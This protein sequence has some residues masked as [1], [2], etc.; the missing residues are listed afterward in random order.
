MANVAR[1]QITITDLN[2]GKSLMFYLSSNQGT[3]QI[4]NVDT[5]TYTPNYPTSPYLVITPELYVSGTSTNVIA[6][7]KAR[8]TVTINGT[9][10]TTSNNTTYSAVVASASP[11]KLTIKKNLAANMRIEYTGI[12]VDPDTL[13]ETTVR[14]GITITRL[15]TAGSTV[16]PFVTSSGEKFVNGEVSSIVL[17]CDVHRGS[18][19]DTTNITYQWQRKGDGV[20]GQTWVNCTNTAN[21]VAGATTQEMTIYPDAVLN[22]D[23][24]RCVITDTDANSATNGQS[25][26]SNT[27]SVI[28]LSDPYTLDVTSTTGNVLTAGA[29]STTLKV[30][31]RRGGELLTETE[32]GNFTF[33]WT[34]Y[35]KDGNIDTSWGTNGVTTGRTVSVTRNQITIRS[36]FICTASI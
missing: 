18:T 14:A 31:V 12:Y 25:F 8:P 20:G 21:V 17:H 34:K 7:L 35:D 33:S 30:D 9:S 26:N 27:V 2:D 13:A 11:W 32:H 28:D 23:D 15:E 36:T 19:I 16:I 24:F 4:Y 1:G 10:I 29:T 6:N 22:F 5:Q 3:S